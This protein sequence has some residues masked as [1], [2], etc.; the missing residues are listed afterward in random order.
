MNDLDRQAGG[1]APEL[2]RERCARDS[3]W[4]DGRLC[5]ERGIDCP[6]A[7]PPEEEVVESG[8]IYP[9]VKF[10]SDEWPFDDDP[11]DPL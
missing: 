6:N 3:D 2:E 5:R 4:C 1:V 11:P 8:Y 7:D 9:G 10:D